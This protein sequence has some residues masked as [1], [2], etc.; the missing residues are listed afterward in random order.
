MKVIQQHIVPIVEKPIRLQEYAVDLFSEIP[1]KSAV[2]KAIKK[3]LI[4]VNGKPTTTAHFVKEND[5]IELLEIQKSKQKVYRLA[6]EVLY[7]DDYL[8]VINKPAGIS[9]SGN[10]F[11]TIANALIPHIQPSSQADAVQAFPVHRLDYPT[12]GCLIIAKTAK[13]KRELHTMF[14]EHKI[15]K[16]Y[17]AVSVGKMKKT[18]GEIE[19]DVDDKKASTTYNV[20]KSLNS[21]KF[22]ALNLVELYPQTGR[23][24]QLRQHL[25]FLGNPIMGDQKY[26]IETKKHQGYGLYLH[27]F[28]VAFIHPYTKENIR[29]KSKMPV[30]FTR[31]FPDFIES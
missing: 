6:I 3:K 24:H 8:A 2:K 16:T 7:E 11:A 17:R 1:T 23:K 4:L 9:V 21:E 26:Y 31:L 12:S 14:E 10:K 28:A 29:I 19:S 15:D 30:K 18:K 13:A 25:L 22:E 27:A 20:L 5:L